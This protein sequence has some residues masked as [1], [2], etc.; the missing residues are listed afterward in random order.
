MSAQEALAHAKQSMIAMPTLTEG[1]M[2]KM[3]ALAVAWTGIE[4][5]AHMNQAFLYVSSKTKRV[6]IELLA[7]EY[8]PANGLIEVPTEVK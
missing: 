7:V 1:E 8:D 2:S 5:L 4:A 3:E 6:C